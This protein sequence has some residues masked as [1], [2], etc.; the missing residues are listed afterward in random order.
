MVRKGSKKNPAA[1]QLFIRENVGLA[2]L[3]TASNSDIYSSPTSTSSLSK[4]VKFRSGPLRVT[5]VPGGTSAVVFA[6][7]RKIPEGY[8]APAITIT[9]GNSAFIDMGN[10]IGYGMIRVNAAVPDPMNRIDLRM[11]QKEVTLL[12][13]DKVTLQ[14]VSNASSLGQEYSVLYEFTTQ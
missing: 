6:I 9:D 4:P 7:L 14:V 5:V 8:S 10:V 1:P 11:L 13:G 2:V 12:R 3:D